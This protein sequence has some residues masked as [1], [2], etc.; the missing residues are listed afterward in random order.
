MHQHRVT[1][2]IAAPRRVRSVT[3]ERTTAK[4]K[5][6]QRLELVWPG[7][8]KFLL[9]PKDE[10]G[11]PVWVEPDHPAAREV[12]LTD[13]TAEHG[14][15]SEDDPY[16][17]NLLFT[18]DSLDVL[19]VLREVPEYA[20]RYR[21]KVKLVA[22]DPPFNT[23]QTFTH[24]DDWMEHSTWLSFMRDRLLLIKDLL[25]P[26]GS[27]WIHLDDA[28]V[29]RMRCLMDEVFGAE[30][31]EATI[32]WQKVTSPRND[33]TGFSTSQDCILVYAVSA[34]W[35]PN[36]VA[37][38]ASSNTSRYKSRDGDP[39]PWR[40]GDATAGKAAT[41]HPMVYAIQHPVTGGLMYPTPGRCWGKA[42]VWFLKQ[43]N[44][45]AKYELRDIGDPDRRALICGTTASKVKQSVP[46]IMLAEP[47][48]TAAA[49]ARERHAAGMWPE[50][51]FLDIEKERVQRKKHLT[52]DGRVPE[53]LW[54]A[55]DV[56]G[57]LRGKN[58]IRALFPDDHAFATPKP[59]ELLER[60][61]HIGSNSGDI[62]LDCFGGSG[63]TAAVAHKMGRRWVTAEILPETVATFTAARLKLVVDGKDPGGVTGSV[64]WAGG[65][66]FRQ[67]TVAPSMYELTP[68]GVMLADWATN[69]RFAR[70]VAGQLGFEWQ[71]KK[72]AP[73]CGVRGRMRLAVLDGAVG[74]EEARVIIAAL[75]ERERVT[76][77]A[78]VVLPG[79]EEFVAEQAKGSR[80]K[81]APRDL[82]TG[83]TR[84]T[85]HRAEGAS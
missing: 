49:S 67:V 76:I 33:T 64:G 52:D 50:L 79:V 82:L 22:L 16:R 78:K 68:L 81:K 60:V 21:G 42:Q 32:V 6:T 62:V 58:Q 35:F 54:L 59:E 19:R 70:A 75:S 11:K 18:G 69:G 25:A 39:V 14:A 13:F 84:P 23:G 29:H 41:N 80:V 47:L 24:Y 43:M 28:E 38:H 71:T 4:D 37:R 3:H 46:A 5:V 36:R 10:S 61:I 51:V 65:G 30:N 63:T 74:I 57:S 66:G 7:K 72:H 85:R 15:V 9:V 8:D 26:D 20:S 55:E 31:F 17:D 73:F 12:R 77:V 40:D 83:R 34:A 2:V 44:N 48:E 53:T 1:E 27:V 45:Y 56:G